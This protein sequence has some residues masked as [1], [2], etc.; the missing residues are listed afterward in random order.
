MSA[1]IQLRGCIMFA[2]MICLKEEDLSLLFHAS[3]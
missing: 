1:N 2:I 3:Q